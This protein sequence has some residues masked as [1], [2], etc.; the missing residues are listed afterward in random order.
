MT[1]PNN[2]QPLTPL[3]DEILFDFHV[4][5]TPDDLGVAGQRSQLRKE[6]LGRGRNVLD[7]STEH[8]VRIRQVGVECQ[9]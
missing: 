3:E 7:R 4:H 5:R 2:T 6:P 9:S 8:I 1:T